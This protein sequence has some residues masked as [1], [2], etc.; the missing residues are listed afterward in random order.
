MWRCRSTRI[1]KQFSRFRTHNMFKIIQEIILY[2]PMGLCCT[3][4]LATTLI[5]CFA[6][7]CSSKKKSEVFTN[8]MGIEFVL[9]PAGSYKMG[10]PEGEM[11]RGRGES[12][13]HSVEIS[14]P[15]FIQTQEVNQSQWKA[16]MGTEPWN[17]KK[18]IKVNCPN[19]PVVYISY[20]DIQDFINK[21]N[22]KE[23]TNRYRLPTEAEW[24]YACRAGTDTAYHFGNDAKK[25]DQYAWY[26]GNTH[27]KGEEYA[28]AVGMKKPNAWG[29]YDMHG[30]VWELCS[31]GYDE[32]YYINSP[33]RDPK[34]PPVSK[35]G[36]VIRG[37]SYDF[38]QPGLRSAVRIPGGDMKRRSDTGFRLVAEKND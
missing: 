1:D 33:P 25:L 23:E 38:I 20:L 9:I 29:L 34:G 30:N 8:T 13:Q 16:L 19:C 26:A 6:T 31:D 32:K 24:E 37:G 22:Q 10:A 3:L 17:G 15:F 7:A 27:K 2:K 28:H 12:P 36:R 4:T 21:L 35:F 11:F 18:R 5:L 14:K